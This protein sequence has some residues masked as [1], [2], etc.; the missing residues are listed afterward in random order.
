LLDGDERPSAPMRDPA[1][2]PEA[3]QEQLQEEIKRVSC[4]D[5]R[6]NVD[7]G[8]NGPNQQ[9]LT[10]TRRKFMAWVRENVDYLPGNLNPEA[11]IWQNMQQDSLSESVAQ[12]KDPKK[13]FE[14]LARKELGREEYEEL[15]SRDILATQTRR[16]A[17]IKDDV[18]EIQALYKLL[19]AFA[20]A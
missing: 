9:Q 5:I 6:F 17:T 18:D 14:A 15:D 12:I 3:A 19:R 4:V 7:A 8:A 1:Q 16:L 10:T 2:I 20:D 11:F 13:R